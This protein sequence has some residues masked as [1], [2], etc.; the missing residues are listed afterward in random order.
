MQTMQESELLP[1]NMKK[2]AVVIVNWNGKANTLNC[3]VSVSKLKTRNTKLETIVLDNGSTDGS[4]EAIQKNFPSVAIIQQTEN[5]G[6]TGGN[7]SGIRKAVKDGADF[8]WLLNNDT[9][10]DQNAL[11]TLLESFAEDQVGITGSKIYFS[12]GSE[13]HKGRYKKAQQGKVLWY[14]GGVIDWANMYASH[15]GVDEVDHGQY[16]AM[17]QTPFV[18]GCSMMVKR[19]VFEKIGL[20]D[21][22]Y[23]LYLEDLDF[24]LRAKQKGFGLV[25]NPESIVWHNNAG[26]S[27]SGSELHQYYMT[28]N[29]LL[30]GMKYA[31]VRTKLALIREGIGYLISGSA[32]RRKAIFDA[33]IGNY[34]KK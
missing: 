33:F 34:G 10:V 11:E 29:R 7:N 32:I 5:L 26:S 12:P 2:V 23:Y 15:R 30:I 3:L 17:G 19:D 27:G 31:P 8:I 16:D 13:F 24:C 14:S 25:Y 4:V 21:D 6:F 22:R 28:R 1:N 9:F 18:T 20:L